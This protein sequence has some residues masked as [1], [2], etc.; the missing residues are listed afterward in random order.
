MANKVLFLDVSGCVCQRKVTLKLV[1]WERKIHPQCGQAP[2]NQL[3]AQPEH[4]RR[5]KVGQVCLLVFWSAPDACFCPPVLGHQTPGSSASRLWRCTSGFPGT[6]AQLQTKGC[7]VSF[8]CVEAFRLE[9]SH[10]RL[11]SSPVYGRLIME[12]PL[13]IM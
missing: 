1:E 8:P 4:S 2:S 10:C 5:K 6:Q 11:L 9:L 12:L 13:I 7:T 3:P